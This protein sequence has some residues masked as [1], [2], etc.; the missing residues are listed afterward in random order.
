M[1]LILKVK[2][3]R[4]FGMI[5]REVGDSR[6]KFVVIVNK[7]T[8]IHYYCLLRCYS[9]RT[10][11]L[12]NSGIPFDWNASNV[13]QVFRLSHLYGRLLMSWPLTKPGAHNNMCKQHTQL[14]KLYQM[15]Y[16]E[17]N[18]PC[19]VSVVCKIQ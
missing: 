7:P 4:L 14:S 15:Y 13:L 8:K 11:I 12:D 6:L 3:L 16:R 17:R 1:L 5:W 2:T 19:L 18:M 9:H 10:V